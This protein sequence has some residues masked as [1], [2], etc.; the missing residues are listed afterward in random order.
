MTDY[1]MEFKELYKKHEGEDIIILG[2]GTSVVDF[3]GKIPDNVTT[4]GVNDIG[5]IYTPEYLLVVNSPK[6]FNPQTRVDTI[7]NNTSPYMITHI[8]DKWCG[9]KNEIVS[10]KLGNSSLGNIS[11]APTNIIDYHNNSPYMA[12]IC[13]Y[14]MGARRIGLIGVDFTSNHFNNNDGEHNLTKTLDSIN[15]KFGKLSKKLSSFGC[16]IYNIS[17]ISKITTLPKM[18]QDEFLFSLND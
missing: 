9:V 8:A 16:D 18:E 7:M 4:I 17:Q 1:K 5:G 2:C 3:V 10:I 15:E 11:N 14:Y 12:C 6:T 13:A